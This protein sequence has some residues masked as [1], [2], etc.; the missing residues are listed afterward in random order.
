MDSVIPHGVLPP[1]ACGGHHGEN[2]VESVAYGVGVLVAGHLDAGDAS[3]GEEPV[4]L[5]TVPKPEDNPSTSEPT[6]ISDRP[7]ILAKAARP[8]ITVPL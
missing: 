1:G 2:G 4:E 8:A 6:R 5:L 7:E 3:V